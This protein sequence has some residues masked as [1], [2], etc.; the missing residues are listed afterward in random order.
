M[1]QH[2]LTDRRVARAIADALAAAPPRVIEIGPGRGALTRPLLAR[3]PSVRA[4]ELDDALA[5][6]LPRALG[7]PEG[8]EVIAGDAVT[9]DLD[10]LAAGG[11]WSLAGNLPYS[12]GTPIVRRVIR[13]GDLFA[14]VV[15]MV[16]L[17]V[18]ERLTAGPGGRGRGLLSVEVEAYAAAELLL[19]VPARCFAPPPRV[20]SAVVRLRPRPLAALPRGLDAALS[21]AGAAFTHRRKTLPNALAG[22]APAAALAAALAVA[23]IEPRRRAEELALAEW[24]ALAAALA[25]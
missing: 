7:S 24:L 19:G 20:A 9:A 16:Q 14:D 8:L 17:E 23:G 22:V 5:R 6:A 2:F 3:F 12:V 25:A 18:A 4:L 13:R 21:L 10:E 11:P 1:G 15:V